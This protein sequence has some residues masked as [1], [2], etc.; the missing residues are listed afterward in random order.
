MGYS[1]FELLGG[2]DVI[3]DESYVAN[4]GP[5]TLNDFVSTIEVDDPVNFGA[6]QNEA[7]NRIDGSVSDPSD[8]SEEVGSNWF[9][10][11]PTQPQELL[12]DMMH[13]IWGSR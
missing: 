3:I 8:D 7:V 4:H 12:S 9:E 6:M 10:Q 13:A 1:T 5:Y 11:M 2:A